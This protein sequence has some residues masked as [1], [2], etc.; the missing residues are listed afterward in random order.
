MPAQ[1]QK[2]YNQLIEDLVSPRA[3]GV[4][5]LIDMLRAPGQGS[6]AQVEYALSGL[7]HY[8]MAKGQESTV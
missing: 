4:Q 1:T 7:S 3:N 2:K 8:V 5:S 6:N